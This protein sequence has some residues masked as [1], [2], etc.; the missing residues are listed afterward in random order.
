MLVTIDSL[1]TGTSNWAKK[2]GADPFFRFSEK[3]HL[4]FFPHCCSDGAEYFAKG[5]IQW[6]TEGV[7]AD[8][9]NTANA[10]DLNQVAPDAGHH[11]PDVEE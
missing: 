5:L 7:D 1:E 11:C 3:S 6:V 8:R 4:H 2:C 10:L 9:I